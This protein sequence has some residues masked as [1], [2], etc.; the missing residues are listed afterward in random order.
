M[1]APA[2]P[3][4]RSIA[5]NPHWSRIGMPVREVAARLAG[6]GR[7]PGVSRP[8]GA[9]TGLGAGRITASDLQQA[10]Q[11]LP[12]AQAAGL[13]PDQ[14][15]QALQRAPAVAHLPLLIDVLD[16]TRRATPGCLGARPSRTRSA[17]PAPPISTTTRPTG[18][19]GRGQGL[20]AF[21]RDTLTHD[22]GIGLLMG[23]PDARRAAGACP[24]PARTRKTGCCSAWAC[25]PRCGPTIWRPCC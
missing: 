10:L 22:H 9:A 18:S 16:T 4:D 6:A 3:L 12:A 7:H 5:V 25:R 17:R 2:W 11:Q 14:C 24:K 19:P 1:I 20:Y 15:L 23:L 21:W 13:T 8:R